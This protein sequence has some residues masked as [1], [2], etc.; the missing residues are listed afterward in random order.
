MSLRFHDIRN[1]WCDNK[2]TSVVS[3][4]VVSHKNIS[5]YLSLLHTKR[6]LLWGMT[7]TAFRKKGAKRVFLGYIYSKRSGIHDVT[8]SQLQLFLRELCHTKTYLITFPSF[9]QRGTFS[10]EWQ[11]LHSEKRVLKEYSLGTF[12]QNGTLLTVPL[13]K[14]VFIFP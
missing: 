6:N 13:V 11:W 7:M 9:I 3:P 2:P 10:E 8:I 14:R 4:W 12:T 1:S 5:H